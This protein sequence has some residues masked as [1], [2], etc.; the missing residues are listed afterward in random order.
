MVKNKLKPLGNYRA[1]ID[2]LRGI[3]VLAV[4][5]YHL[6]FS[7]FKG[8]FVGVDVFFVISG[9][10]ITKIIL[11][12]LEQ[13][14]FSFKHFYVRRIRRLLPALFTVALVVLIMSFVLFP[15][16]AIQSTAGE[17]LFSMLSISN[18]YF[19]SESGYFDKE[20]ITKPLL[21]TWSL[22][23]EEQFYLIWPLTLVL[24]Y[25]YA[26]SAGVLI[27]TTVFGIAS[28]ITS[29][30]QLN[31]NPETAFY[32]MHFRVGEFAL[33]AALVWLRSTSNSGFRWISELALLT[34][35]GLITYSV[36]HFES[37]M[38]FP[39]LAAL[40][41]CIGAAL[42]IYG[43][44]SKTLGGLL[45]SRSF[46]HIGLL[47]YSLY[48]VHWPIIVFYS[49]VR[50]DSLS[51]GSKLVLLVVIYFFATLLYYTVEKP[52]RNPVQGSKFESSRY[53][54]ISLAGSAL[55]ITCI[56]AFTWGNS[57]PIF[58]SDSADFV[59]TIIAEHRPNRG[60]KIRNHQCHFGVNAT[61]ITYSDEC[62]E[63]DY[64]IVGPS[65]AADIFGVFS[66]AYPEKNIGQITAQGCFPQSRSESTCSPA[67]R[68]IEDNA[69]AICE[70]KALLMN[71]HKP[72]GFVYDDLIDRFKSCSVKIYIVGLW[73][74]LDKPVEDI[75]LRFRKEIKTERQ[76][77]TTV[78]KYFNHQALLEYNQDLSRY[79]A[80]R[81]VNY[82]SMQ[83]LFDMCGPPRYLSAD[84][85]LMMLD[86]HHL[87]VPAMEFYG[88]CI[89]KRFSSMSELLNNWPL[90]TN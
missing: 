17:V 84:S 78:L 89:S 63:S 46:V 69:D 62:L 3:A 22:G 90:S 58:R 82:R 28:L 20:A 34:G 2:G 59:S 15:D 32:M 73:G 81:N 70:K 36:L 67:Y 38:R 72:Y 41:P 50:F 56:S 43:G 55:A 45:R 14:Q 85:K 10:L 26:K 87:Q 21:H 57:T 83:K 31:S 19:W 86:T 60:R 52:F 6:E 71:F 48:L 29:E 44:Q 75:L 88:N 51:V 64:L 9:F 68:F 66:T 77:N 76:L 79:A 23:V 4:I 27:G 7:L 35:L 5:F 49:Y 61:N 65:T 12:S 13:N 30:I 25:R 1:D 8:G 47:S 53:F 42:A 39:G 18:F 74:K 24:L 11:A 37:G 16:T 80:N 33:G 54:L 40:V